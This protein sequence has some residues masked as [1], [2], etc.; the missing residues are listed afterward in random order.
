MTKTI[1]KQNKEKITKILIRR[2]LLSKQRKPVGPSPQVTVASGK[3]RNTY[4]HLRKVAFLPAVQRLKVRDLKH[5]IDSFRNLWCGI[6]TI[7]EVFNFS[8]QLRGR[9]LSRSPSNYEELAYKRYFPMSEWDQNRTRSSV[10]ID[11]NTRL[12]LVAIMYPLWLP[13]SHNMADFHAFL[14]YFSHLSHTA[15]RVIIKTGTCGAL[16]LR[17]I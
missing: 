9:G 5:T 4:F 3:V 8:K 16:N 14:T 7:S 15:V 6:Q 12:S 2:W 17:Y 11:I 1:Q 10:A 13:R